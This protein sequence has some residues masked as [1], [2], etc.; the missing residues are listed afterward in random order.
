MHA[1]VC[2]YVYTRRYIHIHAQI[3]VY[4]LYSQTHLFT[5][6][7]IASKAKGLFDECWSKY[8]KAEYQKVFQDFKS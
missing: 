4:T 2:I 8:N 5:Q 3:Y 1:Y 6:S 7:N